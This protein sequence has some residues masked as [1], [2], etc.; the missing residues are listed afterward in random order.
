MDVLILSCGTGGGHDSA[1]RAVFDELN[2]RGHNVKMF[3][4]YT[5]RSK[6]LAGGID[7]TYIATA[8]NMPRA[9]GAV[10]KVGNFY[11][12]LPFHSPVYFANAGMI[13]AMQDY[14]EENPTDVILMPH[15]FP[16]EIMTNMKRRGMKI[17][18]T[19]FIATDYV[20]IPFTEET[21]CDAY[22]IPAEDSVEDFVS[23]GI[24]RE[25][26]YAF[27]IPTHSS[28]ACRET[29]EQAKLRL[30]LDLDKKYIL[31]TGGSMGGGKIEK[32]INRLEKG[33][34]GCEDIEVIV[35]CGSNKEL[36]DRL[37]AR[38][39][40]KMIVVG[41]TEDMASYMRAAHLFITKPGGLSSTEAAV[42]GV[43][44]LHTGAIPGCETIN[45]N[46]FSSHGMSV[47]CDSSEG[48]SEMVCKLLY[49]D[50]ACEQLVM[51]QRRFINR[52]ATADI[53]E[54]VEKAAV[55]NAFYQV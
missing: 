21:E 51:N 6:K 55:E 28:F 36:Y 43:P 10:Y 29:R 47:V 39:S 33:I 23:R 19:V 52:K 18:K 15:L 3:N 25:K 13:S 46:Y 38:G 31:I 17:P 2:R 41:Y 54:F 1:G 35:V 34:A 30:E 11:R 32:V 37:C 45:A 44:I 4:P 9:F 40:S 12:R 50:G 8:R 16:A 22:I 42:C 5:L 20:C 48:I 27:G 53:C 24:P 7:K 26:L 14:L 49:D